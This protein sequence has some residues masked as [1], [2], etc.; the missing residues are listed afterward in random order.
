MTGTIGSLTRYHQA[1]LFLAAAIVAQ[2]PEKEKWAWGGSWLSDH[3]GPGLE[4]L[5]PRHT[6][7]LKRFQGFFFKLWF[8]SLLAGQVLLNIKVSTIGGN[9]T[10]SCLN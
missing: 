3:S 6:P 7:W 10:V 5:Q 1:G 4:A 2:T 9:Y 8:K